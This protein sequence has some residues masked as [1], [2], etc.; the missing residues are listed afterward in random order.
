MKKILYI[1]NIANRVNNFSEASML[2]AKELGYEFHIAGNWGY[3]SEDERITD[4]IKLGIKIFQVDFIRAPYDLRNARAYR[5]IV[6]I[7]QE[8]QYDIVHCNT[9]IGGI[10]GRIAAKKCHV[11]KVIY[12]AHGFHFYIGAPLINRIV[13]KWIEMLLAYWTDVIITINKEDYEAAKK[14]K[15]RN[16]GKVYYVP[17]VGIDTS[18]Y[19][20]DSIKRTELR[21]ELNL[22]KDDIVCISIGNLISRE[23]YD[24]AIKA[25]AKCHDQKI[26]YLICGKGPEMNHLKKIAIELKVEK[27]IHFL[28]F[29]SDIKE[30]LQIA[31]IFLFTSLQEGTPCS[32]LEAMA[33]GLPCIVSKI[34]GN[35]NLLDDGTGGY[36]V[37]V[38]NENI[39]AAKMIELAK[40]SE[41]RRK[42]SL[43]NLNHVLDFDTGKVKIENLYSA[44]IRETLIN[45]LPVRIRKRAELGIAMDSFLILSVGELNT[46][47]NNHI[48]IEAIAET[49]RKDIHY[50]LCGTGDRQQYLEKLAEQLKI[51]R[52][53]HFIGYRRD[54]LDLYQA[55][56]VFAL[57]SFREGLSRSL[58][59]AMASGLPCIASKIRG[60]IDLLQDEKNG[61][62]I[63]PFDKKCIADKIELLASDK[64]L[65]RKMG[66]RNYERAKQFDIKEVKRL[67]CK[68]YDNIE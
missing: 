21:Q 27:Q 52:Q 57:P 56:D 41:L 18:I 49:G 48:I 30:L 15:L 28:G 53:I 36:L 17:G 64:K 10:I 58:L 37:P 24:I 63:S 39:I 59:E 65:R 5:Q 14:F 50:V 6:K 8:G 47:K 11:K 43:E 55:A 7:I 4:E 42:M 23:N 54:V 61:Y 3:Q 16:K 2:A 44:K 34:S 25:I 40:N 46:N 35:V 26:H 33:S 67:I 32:M 9:P 60:N 38:N 68:I 1:L 20:P 51:T 22:K 19:K 29:R 62:L 12:Q 13:F 66:E 45:F 31:D